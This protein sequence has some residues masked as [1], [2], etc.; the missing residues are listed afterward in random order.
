VNPEIVQPE[1][2]CEITD[3]EHIRVAIVAELAHE[4]GG[5]GLVGGEDDMPGRGFRQL[6]R[7]ARFRLRLHPGS[8][9]ELNEGERQQDE[10]E[11]HPG[12]QD[13]NRKEP[14]EIAAKRDVTKAERAHHREGPV[15]SRY[16]AVLLPLEEHDIVEKQTEDCHHRREH[17]DEAEKQEHI[18]AAGRAA[19]KEREL[20]REELH[21]EAERVTQRLWPHTRMS[22]IGFSGSRAWA[23]RLQH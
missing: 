5:D 14:S 21:A 3:D 18:S 7:R 13:E 12:D 20:G 15:E 10:Q 9:E 16:P 11:D 19:G 23:R 2:L 6:A 22:A 8:V 1:C 4:R 17:P